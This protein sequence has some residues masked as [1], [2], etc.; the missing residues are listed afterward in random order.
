MS[1]YYHYHNKRHLRKELAPD[2]V[3]IPCKKEAKML[4]KLKQQTGLT[5]DEL[6]SSPKYRKM[7]SEASQRV[8]DRENKKLNL[9]DRLNKLI[10]RR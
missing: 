4:R 9:V 8:I 2:G 5:E 3:H 7:L 1:Y 6:R 10:N